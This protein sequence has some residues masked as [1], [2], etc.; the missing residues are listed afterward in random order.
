MHR[1]DDRQA[2]NERQFSQAALPT[3]AIRMSPTEHVVGARTFRNRLTRSAEQLLRT[4]LNLGR[5]ADA[6]ELPAPWWV[7]LLFIVFAAALAPWII[8]LVFS[9]PSEQVAS[10]WEIVWGGFDVGLAVLLFATAVTLVRR[11]PLS[12]I[13]AAMAAALLIC[14]AW[15]DVMTARVEASFIVA[16]LE[17]FIVELPLALMCLWIARNVERVV[18]DV[19]PFRERAGLSR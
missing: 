9:L 1:D 12:E 15:F 5:P 7:P 16:L 10:H 8:W 4:R 18:A 3:S 6:D 13:F 11:S 14:D 17:A 19:R 2:E